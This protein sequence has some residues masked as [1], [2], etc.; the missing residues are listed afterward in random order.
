MTMI[1]A[2]ARLRWILWGLGLRS[3]RLKSSRKNAQR[4][5]VRKPQR[6]QWLTV[7]IW[8]T[9]TANGPLPGKRLPVQTILFGNKTP[10]RFLWIFKGTMRFRKKR[11]RFAKRLR[12]RAELAIKLS[13]SVQYCTHHAG[14]MTLKVRNNH[15]CWCCIKEG[16]NTCI[17]IDPDLSKAIKRQTSQGFWLAKM[18]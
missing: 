10:N 9:V 13:E 4:K 15:I 18:L 7:I 14:V 1:E 17:P 3:R 2:M 12:R 11:V 5:F 8:T 6:H 16:C